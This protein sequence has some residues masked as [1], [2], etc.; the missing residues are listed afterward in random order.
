MSRINISILSFLI[1][2]LISF[3]L[4]SEEEKLPVLGDASS[5]VISIAG[6][7]ATEHEGKDAFQELD[8]QLLF[9][10]ITKKHSLFVKQN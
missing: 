3:E 8:Q 4:N 9:E 1:T 10:P 2:V 6:A 7:I 5:S